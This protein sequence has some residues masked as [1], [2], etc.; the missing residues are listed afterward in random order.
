[1]SFLRPR[2]IRKSFDLYYG[3]SF[4]TP[5]IGGMFVLLIWLLAGAFLGNLITLVLTYAVSSSFATGYGMLMAYPVMFIPA[6]MYA[7]LKSKRNATFDKGYSL[8]SNHYGKL[9]WMAAA[10]LVMIATAAAAFMTDAINCLMPPTP[11]W[12]E[13]L[14]KAMTQGNLWVNFLSVSIFAPIFEE[15]LCRGEVLRGLLNH[16]RPDGSAMDPKWAIAI[17]AV[18]FAFIHLNPWQAVPA[19]ILGV[20]FGYVYYKT[21]SLWLTMLMHFTNNTLALIFSNIDSLKDMN[22]W[23]DVLPKMTYVIC[24][25]VCGLVLLF[26][27]RQLGKIPQQS[28]EGNCDEVEAN[29]ETI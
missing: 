16:R 17:S 20:L 9:G 22:T 29:P 11:K 19:F 14:M 23:L 15:W 1:M 5:G 13:N 2:K 6:M 4:Y 28:P 24:F 26:A 10:I 21:G 3:Y 27:V 25:I 8:T 18:F 7:S 12:L